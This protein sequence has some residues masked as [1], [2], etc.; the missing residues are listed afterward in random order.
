MVER[1]HVAGMVGLA[2]VAGLVLR[3]P[4]EGF[5]LTTPIVR[6]VS[7]LA[8]AVAAWLFV[9]QANEFLK[10]SQLDWATRG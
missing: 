6:A 5:G 7:L 8:V 2:I 9:S 10:N 4:N 3:R 1:P